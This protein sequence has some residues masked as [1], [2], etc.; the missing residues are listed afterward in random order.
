MNQ[1]SSH[2]RLALHVQHPRPLLDA[3]EHGRVGGEYHQLVCGLERQEDDAGADVG[4]ADLR[5][6]ALGVEDRDQVPG[7]VVD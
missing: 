4:A 6:V 1:P 5:F 3:L 2:R 7:H